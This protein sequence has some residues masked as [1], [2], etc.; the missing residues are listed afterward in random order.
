LEGWKV[1]GF[2]VAHKVVN[3]TQRSSDKS[4]L[5]LELDAAKF[6]ELLG[7]RNHDLSE[8]L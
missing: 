1:G 2:S 7:H 5:K 6:I 8:L 3:G 4:W